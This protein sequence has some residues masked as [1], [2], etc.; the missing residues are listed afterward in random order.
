ML[1]CVLGLLTTLFALHS[2]SEANMILLLVKF[3][4]GCTHLNCEHFLF[5]CQNPEFILSFVLYFSVNCIE[6]GESYCGRAVLESVSIQIL[7]QD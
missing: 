6:A 7:S 5:N 4:Q 1:F 3:T 2:V